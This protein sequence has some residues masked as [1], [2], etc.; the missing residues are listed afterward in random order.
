MQ[1]P[2]SQFALERRFPHGTRWTIWEQD[3]CRFSSL[4]TVVEAACILRLSAENYTRHAIRETYY[5]ECTKG[6]C[7]LFIRLDGKIYDRLL[8]IQWMK[9]SSHRWF[10]FSVC[11][12][13]QV[14]LN[15]LCECL[16]ASDKRGHK[17]TCICSFASCFCK[18]EQLIKVVVGGHLP[19]VKQKQQQKQQIAHDRSDNFIA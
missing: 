16:L 11:E 17:F 18:V 5:F 3:G 8:W 15:L 1:P 4:P 13:V 7:S 6:R 9:L 2:I 10:T 12:Y 14:V 19:E